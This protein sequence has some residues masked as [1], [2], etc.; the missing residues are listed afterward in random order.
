MSIP[1][2]NGSVTDRC[3]VCGGSLPP[4]RPR[5]TCSDRCRQTAWRRRHQ[6]S[7]L[8]VKNLPTARRI[9]DHTV[10]QCPACDTRLL[11][12]QRCDDC[13]IFCRRLGPGGQCPCCDE[14]ITIE[15][16]LE[17]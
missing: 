17:G 11:G 4:G 6:S 14:P 16:L 1:S 13:N 8:P 2:H 3:L 7:P 9:K 12:Q 15:E 10:Y 5:T